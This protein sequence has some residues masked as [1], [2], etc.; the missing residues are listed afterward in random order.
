MSQSA[1]RVLRLIIIDHNIW[2]VETFIEYSV[3][4]VRLFLSLVSVDNIVMNVNAENVTYIVVMPMVDLSQ[5]LPDY[6]CATIA[7][8][9]QASLICYKASA[10]HCFEIFQDDD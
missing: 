6:I 10:K 8:I 3:K 7:T 4:F 2:H 1:T 5:K 9:S